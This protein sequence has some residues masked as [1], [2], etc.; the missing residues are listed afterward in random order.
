MEKNG[1][2]SS[3][4]L[5]SDNGF[6]LRTPNHQHS[7]DNQTDCNSSSKDSISP[8][9]LTSNRLSNSSGSS[10]NERKRRLSFSTSTSPSND[11]DKVS[12]VRAAGTF[13][14]QNCD[15][16]N[17]SSIARRK[18]KESSN[19]SDYSVQPAKRCHIEN[20]KQINVNHL[21]CDECS[22]VSI[23]VVKHIRNSYLIG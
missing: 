17:E 7:I 19:A 23:L 6:Q 3:S 8:Q 22:E 15:D 11:T 10:T 20:C 12:I 4:P 13:F 14:P 1:K 16:E 2:S 5:S 18:S 21:H 9:H